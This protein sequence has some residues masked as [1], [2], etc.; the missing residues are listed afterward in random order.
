[1]ETAV[2]EWLTR[3]SLGKDSRLYSYLKKRLHNPTTIQST[4]S[5]PRTASTLLQHP[6][7]T[8]VSFLQRHKDRKRSIILTNSLTCIW[9]FKCSS[10]VLLKVAFFTICS[11]VEIQPLQKGASLHFVCFIGFKISTSESAHTSHQQVSN[12]QHLEKHLSLL[13]KRRPEFA[14][15]HGRPRFSV[16]SLRNTSH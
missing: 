1:M 10:R 9:L 3:L 13:N 14:H 12:C 15:P 7:S 11:S 2:G 16:T 5:A 8:K 4:T 6:R